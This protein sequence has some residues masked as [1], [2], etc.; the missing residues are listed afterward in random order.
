M[1]DYRSIYEEWMSNPYFDEATKDE[2]RKIKNN[3]KYSATFQR[4]PAAQ[5]KMEVHPSIDPSST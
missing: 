5:I 3:E 4:G 1:K 2:L